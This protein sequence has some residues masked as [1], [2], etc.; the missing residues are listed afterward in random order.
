MYHIHM[1]RLFVI[2]MR[3]SN[4][5]QSLVIYMGLPNH[6]RGF[7]IYMRSSNH[8]QSLVIYM[9]LPNHWRGFVI[10]MRSSNHWQSL[11]IYMGLP[12]HCLS[13]LQEVFKK[14]ANKLNTVTFRK[15]CSGYD[16]TGNNK[17]PSNDISRISSLL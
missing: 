1:A 10:Y 7:V 2:Y 12:N 14:L 15:Y 4:H 16:W 8:W 11:V 5:W 6:W 3:S 9:G 13:D 17:Y